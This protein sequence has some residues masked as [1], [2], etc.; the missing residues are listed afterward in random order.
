MPSGPCRIENA[1][2]MSRTLRASGPIL[3]YL[4]RTSGQWPVY[5]I[6]PWVAFRPTIPVSAAG[7]R[8]EIARSLPM[9]M[10]ESPAAIAADSP[11]LEPPGVR[12][13]FHG[14]LDKPVTRLSVSCQA[15]NSGRLV[16]AS[17]GAP[18]AVKRVTTLA[19]FCGMLS[20]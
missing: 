3:Q 20:A 11:P 16:L 17:G 4:L 8:T 1:V 2:E 6:R 5:G 7:P 15:E 18:A 10:G 19:T 14:F 13:R 9:P 12:S